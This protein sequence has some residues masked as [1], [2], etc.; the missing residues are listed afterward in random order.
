MKKVEMFC[1]EEG[2]LELIQKSE[3]D[4]CRSCLMK[5]ACCGCKDARAWEE[6]YGR[7]L[8]ARKLMPLA[9]QWWNYRDSLSQLERATSLMIAARKKCID[10]GLEALLEE[11]SAK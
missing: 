2:D 7:E 1:F 8:K 6:K 4:P 11:D 9:E 10:S 5:A 3:P